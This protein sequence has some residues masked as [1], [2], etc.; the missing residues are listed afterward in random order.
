MIHQH[1][2]YGQRERGYHRTGKNRRL[3]QLHEFVDLDE[4]VDRHLE[5][6][7]AAC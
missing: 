3:K 6:G 5:F 1:P 7:A 4:N 2:K